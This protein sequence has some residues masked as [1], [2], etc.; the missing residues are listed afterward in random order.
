[1]IVHAR[2]SHKHTQE[3]SASI[4][5]L[6]GVA[7]VVAALSAASASAAAA[8]EAG[9]IAVAQ[10]HKTV[11]ERQ[12]AVAAGPALGLTSDAPPAWFLERARSS[13]QAH[14]INV[15]KEALERAETR[16]LDDRASA[17]PLRSDM[18]DRTVLD[19]GVARRALSV[20]DR[21]RALY[22]ID[23]ALAALT[24]SATGE[25]PNDAAVPAGPAAAPAPMPAAATPLPPSPPPPPPVRTFVLL[26]GHWQLDGSTYVW[27]RGD[28]TLRPVEPRRFVQGHWLWRDR[29]WMW[30]PDHYE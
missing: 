6:L 30:V 24:V 5:M 21:A 17:P 20:G 27:V 18:V 13:I 16:L 8:D 4:A 26:P 29:V 14:R 23:D 28:E 15:A 25:P 3:F 10:A 1:M 9:L 19:V 2:T 22:A 12:A 7:G 11:A